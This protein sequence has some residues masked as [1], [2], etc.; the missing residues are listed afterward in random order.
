MLTIEYVARLWSVVEDGGE[1]STW[2]RRLRFVVTPSA[3]LDLV[4]VVVTFAPFL[5]VNAMALRLMRR[6]RT[7]RLAKLGRLSSSMGHLITAVSSRRYELGLTAALACGVLIFGETALYWIEGELQPDKFGSIPRA[8]WW[9]VVTLTTIGYGDVF[10][11]TPLGKVLA[12][13]VAFAGIGLI[14]MPTGILAAAFSDAV[15]RDRH[16]GR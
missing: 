15:Q 12:G 2:R 4:A 8:L 6:L 13:L 10:P 3:I 7:V 11:V 5:G 16:Q 14:A 1:Q 9:A